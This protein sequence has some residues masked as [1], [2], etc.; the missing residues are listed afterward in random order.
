MKHCLNNA[1]TLSVWSSMQRRGWNGSPLHFAVKGA[2]S[3]L[4]SST[5][6]PLREGWGHLVRPHKKQ[7]EQ[8][9]LFT[10]SWTVSPQERQT[11]QPTSTVCRGS[12]ARQS[13]TVRF[14][15]ARYILASPLRAE[16]PCKLLSASEASR[17]VHE[18]PVKCL[19]A[20]FGKLRL[21]GWLQLSTWHT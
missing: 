15:A 8:H 7:N 20:C 12:T 2:S 11:S 4:C 18:H 17:P 13:R 16:W 6:P 21:P 3:V 5:Q 10:A 14:R 9:V 19:A 1:S